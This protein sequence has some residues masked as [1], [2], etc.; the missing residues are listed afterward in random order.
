MLPRY[1]PFVLLYVAS[2]VGAEPKRDRFGDPLPEGAIARLGDLRLRHHTSVAGGDFSPDGKIFAAYEGGREII[3]WDTT[4]GRQ[5]RRV[6][7]SHH[8]SPD[9]LRYS[10]DGKRLILGGDRRN[11]YIIDAVTGAERV[12]LEQRM[13][14]YPYNDPHAVDLSR[15]GTTAVTVYSGKNLVVWDLIKGKRRG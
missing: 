5:V 14:Q 10:P 11:F 3:C 8:G 13:P 9:F 7:V 2:V 4:S 12:K 1:L 6:P 15:D